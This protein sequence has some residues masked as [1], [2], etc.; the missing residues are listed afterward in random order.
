[1][2][3]TIETIIRRN[4]AGIID[5]DVVHQTN[6]TTA[7]HVYTHHVFTTYSAI[8]ALMRETGATDIDICQP[9]DANVYG[10]KYTFKFAK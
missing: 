6:G 5:M 9:H 7:V 1:M 4:M 2:A 8:N 3:H 10:L